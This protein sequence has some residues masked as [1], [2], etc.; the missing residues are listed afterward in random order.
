MPSGRERLSYTNKYLQQ[1]TGSQ[2]NLNSYMSFV[3]G[4]HNAAK[5]KHLPDY[6]VSN[7]R[8]QYSFIIVYM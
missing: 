3:A 5:P 2:G 7:S 4:R 1:Y 6:T 8:R